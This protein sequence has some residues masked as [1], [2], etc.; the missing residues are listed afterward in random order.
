MI[1]DLRMIQNGLKPDFKTYG[2]TECRESSSLSWTNKTRK[3]INYNSNAG[4]IKR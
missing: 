2:T 3:A 1:A 4:R